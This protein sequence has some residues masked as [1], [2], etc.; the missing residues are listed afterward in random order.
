MINEP[1]VLAVTVTAMKEALDERGIELDGLARR[2][3][4]DLALLRR[5]GARF[6]VARMRRL[7]LLAFE[8][9]GDAL[10]GLHVGQ[11]VRPG[12]FHALG[13]GIVTSPTLL[14]ALRRVERYSSIVSTNGRAVVV[15]A[16]GVTRLEVQ[17][18]PRT[19]RQTAYGLDAL[20][21]SLARMLQLCAGTDYAPLGITLTHSDQGRAAEYR[22]AFGCPVEF[23]APRL[24]FLFRT[25]SIT[26]PLLSGD[27][28]LAAES[29]RLAARY[30]RTLQ[31][32][33]T[34]TRVRT[35]LLQS[36]PAGQVS[37]E[38]VAQAL[39]Q[40]T[41]TLQRRLRGEGTSFQALLDA[42]RRELALDY[43]RS[44]EHSVADIAFLLGFSDQSNFTRAFRRW[45][46]QTPRE[47]M[48]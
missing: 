12:M 9:T 37:Q 36:L 48:Q 33:T 20:M 18:T 27:P 38:R 34:A 22:A 24:A 41:S 5:P 43:L 42:T 47:L 7:W 29:D 10:F 14:D 4:I 32:D 13:L 1:T 45:T 17:A 25:E 26:Q 23:D 19:I 35:L 11:R 30:L 21:M 28:D 31:P 2:V 8:L 16:N 44:G 46:G 39:H 40:S 3:G 15:H 6:P